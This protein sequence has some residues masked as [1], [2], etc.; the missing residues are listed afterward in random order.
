MKYSDISYLPQRQLDPN[1]ISICSPFS[2]RVRPLS[3]HPEPFF[4]YGIL[5][6]GIIV[7]LTSHKILA[8]FN[9]TLLQVKNAGSEFI[10][11]A[12]NG[13]K[14]LLTLHLDTHQHHIAHT[15]IAQLGGSKIIK[16]E[17]LAYFDLRELKTPLLATMILLNGNRLGAVHYGLSHVTAGVDSL[18]TI[19]KK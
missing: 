17:R 11:K 5:G 15:H 9:G 19:T 4:S 8:P 6:R 13:L 3:E 12:N 7:E 14:V 16:G 1:S 2:G 10:L 18:L